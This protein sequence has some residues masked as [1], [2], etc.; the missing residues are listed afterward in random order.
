MLRFGL[1]GAGRIGQVHGNNIAANPRAKLVAIFDTFEDSAA[2]LARATGAE[3]RSM[4]EIIKGKDI[5]VVVICT[6]TDTHSD[7][8]ERAARAGKA[9]FC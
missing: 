1:L 4:D 3:V 5:D 6:P 7:L 2:K 8:I 9:I